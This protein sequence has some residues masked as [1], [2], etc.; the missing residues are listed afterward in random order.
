MMNNNE[1]D[2]RQHLLDAQSN[3]EYTDYGVTASVITNE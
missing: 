3:N 1:N 2:E